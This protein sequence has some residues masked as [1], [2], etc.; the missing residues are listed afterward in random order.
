MKR[1]VRPSEEKNKAITEILYGNSKEMLRDLIIK[2]TEKI[3]QEALESEVGEYL[4]RDWYSHQSAENTIKDY[5]NGY[6][7]K[8]Y[9]TAEG[10]LEIRKPRVRTGK[11]KS[12]ILDKLEIIENKLNKIALES[13]VRG[14]STRDIES[15]FTDDKGA[16]MLSR[17]SVSNLARDLYREYEEFSQRDLT[18]I[19]AV[20]LFVD[21][22]YEAVRKYT[23]NQA[24]LCAWAITSDGR[25]ELLSLMAVSSEST[26]SYSVFFEDMLKRGLR[27][28]LLV[29]SDGSTALISAITR[30]FPKADRQRCVAHKLRNL[31]VKVPKSEQKQINRRAREVYFATDKDTADVIA[32]KFIEDYAQKYPSMVKCFTDD[33]QSCLTQ[34]KYP[35]GHRIHIRTT[36]LIERAFVEEKRRTKIIPQHQNEKG[37]LG[38]VFSVLIR[39]SYSWRNIKMTDLELTELKHIRAIICPEQ[40]ET[41]FISYQLVA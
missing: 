27:Q 23:R 38:L 14:L 15:T 28:P 22:V 11:F 34:M 19:D 29:V 2:S 24:I 21:G 32:S 8:H 10:V 3:L 5:R 20:Y 6:Q 37:A 13:Y 26:D 40:K 17:S 31:S 18:K 7:D 41:G 33:L 9:K 39:A 1:K 35:E 25:K 30:S 36:N 12:R 4:G 16:P